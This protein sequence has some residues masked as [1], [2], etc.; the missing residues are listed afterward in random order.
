MDGLASLRPHSPDSLLSRCCR[1]AAFSR[2]YIFACAAL[3]PCRLYYHIL[4]RY[5][6]LDA[7]ESVVGHAT[8]RPFW[9]L[10][11]ASFQRR[12]RCQAFG[13]S[14]FTVL[15]KIGSAC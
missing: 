3:L 9:P 15:G 1:T 14:T 2:R 7:A 8:A 6:R 4:V 5:I 12:L 11:Y 10:T 13:F